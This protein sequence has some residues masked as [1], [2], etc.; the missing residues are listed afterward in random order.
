MLDFI[1]GC[2][3]ISFVYYVFSSIFSKGTEKKAKKT[4]VTKSELKEP[5]KLIHPIEHS[6]QSFDLSTYVEIVSPLPVTK[7]SLLSIGQ[8]EGILKNYADELEQHR[9]KAEKAATLAINRFDIDHKQLINQQLQIY[10]RIYQSRKL[11]ERF[12]ELN[13]ST[14]SLKNLPEVFQVTIPRKPSYP[15]PDEL[16]RKYSLPPSSTVGNVLGKVAT[17]RG[18]NP[19]LKLTLAAIIAAGLIIKGRSNN[20]KMKRVLEDARGSISNYCVSLK[21]TVALLD[22]TH[23]EL[24]SVSNKLKQCE[25]ELISMIDKIGSIDPKIKKLDQVEPETRE[26]L[27]HFHILLLK[28]EQHSKTTI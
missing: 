26:K 25:T 12:K 5:P 4:K 23:P 19:T 14:S 1:F 21:T 24:V 3:I 6:P 27:Y 7:D 22:I 9:F 10:R 17:A 8:D 16:R 2:I 13:E 11:I 28:A 20:S 15:T 18:A